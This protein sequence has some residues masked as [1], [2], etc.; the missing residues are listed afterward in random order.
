M[1][2]RRHCAQTDI[3]GKPRRRKT[4]LAAVPQLSRGDCVL[5]AVHK[6]DTK[7]DY[8]WRGPAQILHQVNPQVFIVEPIAVENVRPFPVHIRRLRR[9]VSPDLGITEQLRI[10]VVRDHADNVVQKL[11]A[12][13]FD[14]IL[15]F[16][17]R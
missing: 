17:I 12:H 3:T 13:Q 15:L 6:P 4:N 10:D 5:Y 16:K 14:G 7:L 1:G 11:T 8:V 2:P 9:F